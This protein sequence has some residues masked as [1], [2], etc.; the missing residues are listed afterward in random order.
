MIGLSSPLSC[1]DIDADWLYW[2]DA[3]LSAVADHVP[4]KR[5]KGRNH[6]PWI[7]GTIINTTK[8]KEA[9]RRRLKKNPSNSTLKEKYKLLR[10]ET[11]RLQRESRDNYLGSPFR[12]IYG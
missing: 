7:T 9:A 2:R 1:D 12:D 8:K 4:T 11:K 6:V 3:S 10:S 5:L